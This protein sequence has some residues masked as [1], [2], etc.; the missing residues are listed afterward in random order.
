MSS[1]H[2]TVLLPAHDE[3]QSI[4]QVLEDVRSALSRVPFECEI[5][6]VDD[7]STD[8]TAAI[9]RDMG[10]RVVTHH[11]RM[12]AG[13]A[14]KT[15]ILESRG[16]LVLI[17]DADG[18]YPSGDIPRILAI[19]ADS[20]QV[21]GARR[22]EAGTLPLLRASVK[23]FL[24]K[25]G[26]FLVRQRIP[27]IN[28]GMRAFRRR[29]AMAFLHLL[30]DGHSCVSTLTLCFIG[31][32][33]P[34]RF[35]PIDY[36]PRVGT[37]KFRVFRDTARFLVQI[38]RTVTYFAPLRVFLPASFAFFLAGAGKSVWDWHRKG[39]LEESDIVL[40]TFGA[41]T[42]MMGLLADLI[43]RQSRRQI[44]HDLFPAASGPQEPGRPPRND[45]PPMGAD[46]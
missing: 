44:L 14:I 41:I 3:E 11:H 12:G 23:F 13:A 33:L 36:F 30:P 17:M 40:L 22:K 7:G 2:A 34:V 10:A 28:S 8:R 38:V 21:I 5:L 16:D 27:D 26:E 15:G 46:R 19:L 37:S 29:D 31:M 18:T 4:P 43:V 24:R 9:A 35:E 42:G 6:L 45:E 25:L 20:R 1:P 39:G 32:G